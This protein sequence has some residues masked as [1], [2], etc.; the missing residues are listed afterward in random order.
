MW[1]ELDDFETPASIDTNQTIFLANVVRW[2]S[3]HTKNNSGRTQLAT[4]AIR[5]A[6]D[7]FHGFGVYS[8]IEVFVIAGVY[9]YA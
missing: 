1:R 9:L 2:I 8:V 5:K 6:G 7:V 3:K 4:D